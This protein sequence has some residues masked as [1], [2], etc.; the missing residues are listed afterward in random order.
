MRIE[1]VV[2]RHQGLVDYLIEEGIITAKTTVISHASAETVTGKHVLGVLPHSLS[3]LCASFTEIPLILPPELRGQE[4]TADDVRK[5]A[6]APVTYTIEKIVKIDLP[7]FDT[8][9][10][11][12]TSE[13]IKV[14][15]QN[16]SERKGR[17]YSRHFIGEYSKQEWE[18]HAAQCEFE[19]LVA[20][21][22]VQLRKERVAREIEQEKKRVDKYGNILNEEYFL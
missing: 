3:C 12:L 5:H 9:E 17:E 6:R 21:N 18:A 20:Q 14:W 19:D 10:T 22:I 1:L 8:Y 2:T 11:E 16:V 4:L 15:G 13:G 7:S